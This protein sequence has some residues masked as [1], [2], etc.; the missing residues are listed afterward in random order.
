MSEGQPAS[1]LDTQLAEFNLRTAED[2]VSSF[3]KRIV[4][5]KSTAQLVAMVPAPVQERTKKL[6][7][8]I[9]QAHLK[10]A[11]ATTI[12]KE[13]KD[14]LAKSNFNLP[15][16]KSIRAPSVQV[17]KLAT[18]HGQLDP[19]NFTSALEASKRGALERM[20]EIKEGEIEILDQLC[21]SDVQT[22]KLLAGWKT[23]SEDEHISAEALTILLSHSCGI[24]LVKTAISIGANAAYRQIETKKKKSETQKKAKVDATGALPGDKKALAEFI[25][26]INKRQ[27]QST[28]DK[29]KALKNKSGKGQGGAGPSKTKN[30]KKKTNK[31]SK[32]RQGKSGASSG[33]QQKKR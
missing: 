21:D 9:V 10:M 30:Q 7:E 25:K 16:L 6:L 13:W 15:E 33:R 28:Q 29:Q 17:S 14:S 4:N 27:R 3:V 23:A 20:I 11:N 19:K 1:T 2:L 26:E 32:R 22:G 8:Q 18:D 5:A 31:V 24:S 12:L